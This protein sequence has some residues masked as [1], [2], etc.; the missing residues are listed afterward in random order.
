[1]VETE[2]GAGRHERKA[3]FSLMPVLP[4]QVKERGMFCLIL[5]LLV[6]SPPG[7]VQCEGRVR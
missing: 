2:A 6:L 3:G 4:P 7:V 1:M 5:L